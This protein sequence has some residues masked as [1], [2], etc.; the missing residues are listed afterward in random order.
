SPSP[1][2]PFSQLSLAP[3]Q[4]P[5]ASRSVQ[6]APARFPPTASSSASP[7]AKSAA[8]PRRTRAANA[9]PTRRPKPAPICLD[10]PE[11][12]GTVVTTRGV[13]V[14]FCLGCFWARI[15]LIVEEFVCCER[16]EA[17]CIL[18]YRKSNR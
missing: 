8:V 14:C 1:S 12:N 18:P 6:P 5:T 10:K 17:N 4:L 9:I 11:R 2:Y 16:A 15:L 7:H 13:L 3:F